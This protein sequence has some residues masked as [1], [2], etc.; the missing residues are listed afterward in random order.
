MSVKDIYTPWFGV[1]NAI[2]GSAA[3]GVVTA[4]QNNDQR[5]VQL[6]L[7]R[8]FWGKLCRVERLG[9]SPASRPTFSPCNKP[10]PI[11]FCYEV[12]YEAKDT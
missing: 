12:C 6:A 5:N 8:I 3:F 10:K 2:V 11:C 7:K 1:S 4:A 9:V